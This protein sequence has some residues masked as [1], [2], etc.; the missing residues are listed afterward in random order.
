MISM[1]KWQQIK[2]LR[3]KGMG[4]KGISKKLN[5]SKDTARRY[6]RSA[7]PQ[8]FQSREYLS[9][10]VHAQAGGYGDEIKEM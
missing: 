10:C 1:Y 9:A 5:I 3:C 4:I 7:K 8:V 2:A 6:G